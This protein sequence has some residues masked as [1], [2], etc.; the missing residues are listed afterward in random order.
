MNKLRITIILSIA[1]IIGNQ[2]SAAIK[3]KNKALN[4]RQ[5]KATVLIESIGSQLNAI[6]SLPDLTKEEKQAKA[7]HIKNNTRYGDAGYFFVFDTRGNMVSHPIKPKLNGRSMTAHHETYIRTAFSQFVDTA[8][9]FGKGFVTYQWP[10]PGSNEQE[11]KISFVQ[12]MAHWNWIVGTGI[13]ITDVEETYV[14]TLRNVLLEMVIYIAILL[15]VSHHI[16]RNI[17]KPLNKLTATMTQVANDKDLTIQLKHQGNDEFAKMGIA[18][19]ESNNQFRHVLENISDNTMSLASQAEELSVVT[20]QIKTGIDEQHTETASVQDKVNQLNLS[21]ESVF[22]QTQ[23][24][25]DNV[26]QANQLTVQGLKFIG[27][28]AVNIQ[29]VAQ[30]VKSAEIAVKDLQ[31]S[32]NQIT[33]VLNVIQKVAEQTN[34]LAFNAAIE[35]ARAGEQGRGFA[36]VAD[37]VRTLAMRTQQSTEDI[38][39]IINQLHAGVNTTVSEMTRCKHSANEGLTISEQCNDTLKKIDLAMREVEVSNTQIAGAAQTQSASISS[40]VDNMESIAAI[41]EQTGTGA[42]H[43]HAASQQLSEMS[44]QLSSLVSEFKV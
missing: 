19:N 9:S 4:E 42:E 43:T 35:A 39:S 33:E 37:E 12:K 40:I 18:F 28:N 6:A 30:R 20:Q 7:I 26:D 23:S 16:A 36:V 10:K 38:Q 11:Q 21:A 17:T 3:L 14:K 34:L 31:N 2:I 22:K 1:I 27:D 32:S 13:Y 24:A 8:L 41:A 5:N 15:F 29:Q 25:L 44:Q